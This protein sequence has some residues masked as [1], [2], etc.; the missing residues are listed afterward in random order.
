MSVQ[1]VAVTD[2]LAAPRVDRV[3]HREHREQDATYAPIDD[4]WYWEEVRPTR[5]VR[6]QI[7]LDLAGADS[8]TGFMRLKLGYFE[9]T[10][11]HVLD[12]R[13]NN[14]LLQPRVTFSQ[15]GS[16]ARVFD[17]PGVSLRQRISGVD[18]NNV[19]DLA[20]VQGL[21]SALGTCLLEVDFTYQRR[22]VA[23]TSRPQKR[24]ASDAPTEI[25]RLAGF[26]A[27]A[28]TLVDATDPLAPVRLTGLTPTGAGATTVWSALHGRG[29]GKRAH[30]LAADITPVP[31]PDLRLRNIAPLRSRTSAP[32]MLI[33]T[34]ESLRAAADRLAAH[35]R[36]HWPEPGT[37]DILVVN[38]AEI[39]DDFSGGRLDPLAIR[40]Y[41]KFLYGLDATPRLKY[42]LLFGDATY[43]TRQLLGSSP[44]TLVPT[45]QPGYYD[46][47]FNRAQDTYAVD[48]WLGEFDM[49]R[50]GFPPFPV[51]ELAIGRLAARS[52]SEAERPVDKLI[53]YETTSGFGPWR[54][55]IL[56]S[57]DDECTP[58]GWRRDRRSTTPRRCAGR[59]RA[60]STSC[61]ST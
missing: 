39:Y 5:P 59:C 24:P 54:A 3:W 2:T 51:P 1:D 37:P 60:T 14:L 58:R 49:P 26:G 31:T 35:R 52:P 21:H 18:V 22:L 34:H 61:A 4:L 56:M 48:D 27:K 46:P 23:P 13:L 28:P 25:Y 42:L 19:L 53:G 6:R 11:L 15:F 8:T 30:Y 17:F 33:V 16:A 7:P 50:N 38:T 9:A 12:V 40:N 20:A 36:A 55:R 10:G 29:T 41:A 32:D 45:T 47:R 44:P 57:A 43:D